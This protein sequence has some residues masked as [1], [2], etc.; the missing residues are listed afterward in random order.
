MT[1][2]NAYKIYSLLHER[3]HQQE[4]NESDRLKTLTMDEAIEELTYSLLQAGEGVRKRSAYHPP[5]QRDLQYVFDRNGG[6]KQRTDLSRRLDLAV[7]TG[8]IQPAA[9]AVETIA[10]QRARFNRRKRKYAWLEH[11][12]MCSKDRG[13]CNWENCPGRTRTTKEANRSYDTRYKCIE[14]S[15]KFGKDQYFCN[16]FSNGV[17]RNC[18]D[19]Y[20][21][22]YHEKTIDT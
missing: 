11:H 6:T 18:H 14:C 21:K 8:T 10:V 7:E 9:T 19:L 4:E 16:D 20:H 12:S 13:R 17:T 2:N 3:E 1:L 5:P 22:K 15:M